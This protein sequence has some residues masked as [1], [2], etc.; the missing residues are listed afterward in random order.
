[1]RLSGSF[2]SNVR[3]QNITFD[4]SLNASGF[5]CVSITAAYTGDGHG[6][7][8]KFLPRVSNV[9]FE[10]ID[11]RGCST[12]VTLACNSK[13]PCEGVRFDGVQTEEEFVC[14]NVRCTERHVTT[15]MA[16]KCCEIPRH[17]WNRG[18]IETK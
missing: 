7:A 15:G 17:H 10:G 4:S 9:S 2:I 8:G 14:E 18:M 3:Y 12:P 11:A 5:P 16:N 13:Q 6:Y 1:V